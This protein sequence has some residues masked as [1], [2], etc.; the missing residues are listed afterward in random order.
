MTDPYFGVPQVTY[1]S[2]GEFTRNAA[3]FLSPAPSWRDKV[4]AFAAASPVIPYSAPD[5]VLAF[6][7][8]RWQK[9]IDFVLAYAGGYRLVIIKATDG[10]SID[11]MFIEN[12]KKALD[13]GFRIM[14]YHFFRSNMD[15]RNQADFHLETVK[16]LRDQTKIAVWGDLETADGVSNAV[17]KPRFFTFLDEVYKAVPKVGSYSSNNYWQSLM[18][19]ATLPAKYWFWVAHW[20]TAISPTIP[21]G[22]TKIQTPI[23]QDAV[24]PTYPWGRPVPGVTTAVDNDRW[25]GTLESLDQFLGLNSTPE[26]TD[27]Q[28]LDILWREAGLHGWR[29]TL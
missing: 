12:W 23:W 17:R 5:Y 13:A 7:I 1:G 18:D 21:K 10:L 4:R 15:A 9:V 16:A 26:Y 20:T 24:Y 2:G 27:A 19:N 22:V 25:L 14:T 28:K 3:D 11:P 6:D 29:L 8:S